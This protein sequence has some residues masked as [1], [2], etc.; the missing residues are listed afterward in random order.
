MSAAKTKSIHTYDS[1][2]ERILVPELLG[3]KEKAKDKRYVVEARK[4]RE[5]E[6]R[7]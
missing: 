1:R 4:K 7:W 2:S 3:A 6:S 5:Q